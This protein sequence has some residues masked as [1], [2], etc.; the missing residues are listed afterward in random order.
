[1]NAMLSRDYA[2]DS[3][4]YVIQNAGEH[5]RLKQ[6]A[7]DFLMPV[8]RKENIIID[9]AF[10]KNMV[11]LHGKYKKLC[12]IYNDNITHINQFIQ[13]TK[14]SVSQNRMEYFSQYPES[15][16]MQIFYEA[17]LIT[18]NQLVTYNDLYHKIDAG[19]KIPDAPIII[20]LH[21][22]EIFPYENDYY[23]FKY[24]MSK[25]KTIITDGIAYF[26]LTKDTF[27]KDEVNRIFRMHAIK[28]HPDKG[29]D[30]EQFKLI[31]KYKDTLLKVLD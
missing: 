2:I 7:Y 5:L 27:N 4:I 3:V 19:M 6:K 1:M 13:A 16:G 30:T 24:N 25:D 31:V 18:I 10:A 21:P 20:K 26:G 28:S 23:R 29:G 15:I 12:V 11:F 9:D 8:F 14:L 22:S 17:F